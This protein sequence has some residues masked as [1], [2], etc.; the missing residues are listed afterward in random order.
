MA[1][2][3]TTEA[4][5]AACDAIVD[6]LDEGNQAPGGNLSIYNSD[7]TKLASLR[8]SYPAFGDSADGT[9]T[10]NSITDSVGLTDGTAATFSFENRDGTAVWSGIVSLAGGGGDMELNS[11]DIHTD[12][13]VAVSSVNY[14]VPA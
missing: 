4:Q 7:S 11:L 14:V 3:K 5:N 8:L 1:I 12:T 10:A 13:T 9:A 2:T 6:L